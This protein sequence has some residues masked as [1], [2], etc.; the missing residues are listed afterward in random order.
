M[1]LLVLQLCLIFPAAPLAAKG[2]PIAPIIDTMALAVVVMVVML[3]HRSGA[4]A[5]IVSGL[6]AVLASI[7]PGSE[8]SPVAVSVL[9]HG[10]NILTFCALTGVLSHAVYP[11]A[12]SPFTA[13]RVQACCI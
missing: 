5:A 13:F 7:L 8:W 3:S 11:L 12:A 4:I 9:R 10:G 6:A 2:L 1:V